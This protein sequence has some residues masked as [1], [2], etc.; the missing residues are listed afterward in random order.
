MNFNDT[1]KEFL[2]RHRISVLTVLTPEGAPHSATVH[3]AWDEARNVFVFF[4]HVDTLKYQFV[5]DGAT[6]ASLVI[7]FD[8]KEFTTVQMRGTAKVLEEASSREVYLE[9]FSHLREGA[10]DETVVFLEFDPQ[11]YRYTDMKEKPPVLFSSE[12]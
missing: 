9:K 3:F 7:G 10:N 11:W 4:T 1:V 5:K 8:E 6:K 12:E 2:H